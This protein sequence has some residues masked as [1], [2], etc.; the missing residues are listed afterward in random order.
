MWREIVGAEESGSWLVAC[1]P[2]KVYRDP[3]IEQGCRVAGQF[4]AER[5][6]EEGKTRK[7]G[8]ICGCD[9]LRALASIRRNWQRLPDDLQSCMRIDDLGNGYQARG[10]FASFCS[11]RSK[12]SGLDYTA[13]FEAHSCFTGLRAACGGRNWTH[14]ISCS[15]CR[16]LWK[17]DAI[18]DLPTEGL[19]CRG[20]AGAIQRSL[21]C[22]YPPPS[23]M[24]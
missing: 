10:G 4:R 11:Q 3:C 15:G 16:R 24:F 17:V 7:R 20:L 19:C 21:G 6:G 8:W 12:R 9:D 18:G 2:R 22:S 1:S 5:E 14:M 13:H 23:P